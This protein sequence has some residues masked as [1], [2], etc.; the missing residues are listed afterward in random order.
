MNYD[1]R[2]QISDFRLKLAIALFVVCGILVGCAGTMKQDQASRLIAA[3]LSIPVDH[4]QVDSMSSMGNNVLAVVTLK[5]SFALQKNQQGEWQIYRVRTTSGW[6]PP[7]GFRH[8]LVPTALSRSLSSAF[9]SE[10]QAQ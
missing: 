9:L 3:Q 10:L 5:V 8:H 6:E 7:D 2:F 4:V 1:F